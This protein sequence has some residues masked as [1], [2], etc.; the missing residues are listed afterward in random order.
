M[1]CWG[2]LKR[3]TTIQI[4]AMPLYATTQDGSQSSHF[5]SVSQVT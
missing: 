3:P 1:G 2:E 5:N 4:L